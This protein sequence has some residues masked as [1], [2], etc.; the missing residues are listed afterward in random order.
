MAHINTSRTCYTQHSQ[1]QNIQLDT[2]RKP[3]QGTP[4]SGFLDAVEQPPIDY[5]VPMPFSAHGSC[6]NFSF[7]S[8]NHL[9]S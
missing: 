9:F 1:G 8:L 6:G 4:W 5:A 7:A 3:G 2:T